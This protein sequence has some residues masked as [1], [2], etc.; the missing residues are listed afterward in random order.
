MQAIWV[1]L[2]SRIRDRSAILVRNRFC[3]APPLRRARDAV[4]DAQRMNSNGSPVL[5]SLLD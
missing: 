3:V 1:R 5:P 4:P 2:P